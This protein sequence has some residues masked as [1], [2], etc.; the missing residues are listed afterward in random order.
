MCMYVNKNS[1]NP[2]PPSSSQKP[3]FVLFTCTQ[4]ASNTNHKIIACAY[5]HSPATPHKNLQDLEKQRTALDTPCHTR[6]IVNKPSDRTSGVSL[7][8]LNAFSGPE[9]QAILRNIELPDILDHIAPAML[10]SPDSDRSGSMATTRPAKGD[11]SSCS[12]SR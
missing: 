12:C 5:C 7:T 10:N 6:P 2:N 4:P 1:Q 3:R 9:F 11:A 8:T